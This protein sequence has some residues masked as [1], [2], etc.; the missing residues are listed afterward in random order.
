VNELRRCARSSRREVVPLD[1][2]DGE[3]VAR[4]QFRDA[5]ADDPPADDEQVESLR[6]QPLEA[7]R[8]RVLHPRRTLPVAAEKADTRTRIGTPSLRAVDDRCA[9]P[10]LAVSPL[11]THAGLV[12]LASLDDAVL[13]ALV[14]HVPAGDELTPSSFSPRA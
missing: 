11:R 7:G 8:T 2:R 10:A 3:A 9:Q 13:A 4:R 12:K 1:Q 5:G 14:E 6:P